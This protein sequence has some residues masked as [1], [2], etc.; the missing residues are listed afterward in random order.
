MPHQF[1]VL[2]NAL[3]GWISTRLTELKLFH[4]YMRQISTRDELEFQFKPGRNLSPGW[5][6]QISKWS[7]SASSKNFKCC[8]CSLFDFCETVVAFKNKTDRTVEYTW[9]FSTWS[10]GKKSSA[11][12]ASTHHGLKFLS[13]NRLLCF[14]RILSL[15]AGLK[16]QPGK[17]G[18]NS[19]RAENSPCNQP[20][21]KGC[22]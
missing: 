16:F 11:L 1:M 12:V 7:Y 4:D 21:N 5:N 13:R 2:K 3:P 6:D 9:R 20:L 19:A 15:R 8:S 18:W 22:L 10:I 17:P 14:N